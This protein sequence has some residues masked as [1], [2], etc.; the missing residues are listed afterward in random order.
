M[1]K[2]TN[3]CCK[4]VD[5][6]SLVRICIP[7]RFLHFLAY[8]SLQAWC[9]GVWFIL[10]FGLNLEKLGLEL[11][12]LFWK[13][14][15]SL[16]PFPRIHIWEK[17]PGNVHQYSLY[18]V[19]SSVASPLIYCNYSFGGWLRCA[20]ALSSELFACKAHKSQFISKIWN[21]P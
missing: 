2:D 3:G 7:V 12:L 15:F 1:L 5:N 16:L 19:D 14:C 18:S 10:I 17:S 21:F 8:G 6:Q 9:F 4:L 13:S 11:V 20:Y